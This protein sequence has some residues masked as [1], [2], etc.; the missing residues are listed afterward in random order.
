MSQWVKRVTMH[1]PIS[2]VFIKGIFNS[3][4]DWQQRGSMSICG[5]KAKN[6]ASHLGEVHA[7]VCVYAFTVMADGTSRRH[8]VR[9]ERHAS[10]ESLVC[11]ENDAIMTLLVPSVACSHTTLITTT[12]R[13]RTHL[14]DR[15]FQNTTVVYVT[16]A[17]VATFQCIECTHATRV[18]VDCLVWPHTHTHASLSTSSLSLPTDHCRTSLSLGSS[19]HFLQLCSRF[20]TSLNLN[21]KVTVWQ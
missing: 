2:L 8:H 3:S 17:I 9:W 19:P 6:R 11:H 4:G 1:A 18:L 20:S 5:C 14:T 7:R 12:N 16:S 10:F 13:M 21:T 15:F